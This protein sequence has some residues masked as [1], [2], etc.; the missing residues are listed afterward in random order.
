MTLALA[1]SAALNGPA[2]ARQEAHGYG[3]FRM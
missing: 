3:V 1:L 2:P